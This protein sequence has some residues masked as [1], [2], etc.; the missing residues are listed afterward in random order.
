[1]NKYVIIDSSIEAIHPEGMRGYDTNLAKIQMMNFLNQYSIAEKIQHRLLTTYVQ[2][3]NLINR[4]FMHKYIY[5]LS[6][7]FCINFKLC[8][9]F[10]FFKIMNEQQFHYYT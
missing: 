3:K 8:K 7:A 9:F 2:H 1:M 10:Y 4:N 6:F 5:L